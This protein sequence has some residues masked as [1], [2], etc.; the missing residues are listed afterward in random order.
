MFEVRCL[1]WN[2]VARHEKACRIN[3]IFLLI[4]ACLVETLVF[5]DN[6]RSSTRRLKYVSVTGLTVSVS[7]EEMSVLGGNSF[8]HGR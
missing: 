6:R 7:R 1:T 8:H 3:D 5:A 4:K 2:V